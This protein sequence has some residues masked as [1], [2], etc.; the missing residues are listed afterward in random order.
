MDESRTTRRTFL[1]ASGGLL[2]LVG[3]GGALGDLR[4][5]PALRARTGETDVVLRLD[6]ADAPDEALAREAV[7]DH[8]KSHAETVQTEVRTALANESGVSVT[9]SFWLANALVA[10]VDTDRTRLDDLVALDGVERV[11]ATDALSAPARGSGEDSTVA[12][13]GP[14]PQADI[15]EEQDVSWVLDLL[16]VPEV[17]DRYGTRGEG[18]RVAILDTGVDTSHPDIE[19]DGWAEF[20][21]QG[22]RV[23]SDP[24]EVDQGVGHG[25]WTSTLATGGDES[26]M[27]IGVA[28]DAEL[29]VAGF[30]T[31][32]NF[33]AV[34]A[35]LEW[36]VEN[37]AEVASMSFTM[38]TRWLDVI[39][40][41]ENAVAAGTVP[42]TAIEW[43][44]PFLFN[45]TTPEMLVT[46]PITRDLVPRQGANGGRIRWERALR[47]F[48]VPADWPAD[49]FVP[50]VS[51]PGEEV[52]SG[53]SGPQFP[54]Q[55]WTPNGQGASA[56]PPFAAGIVALLQ[57]ATDGGLSAAK[58]RETFRKTAFQPE[59]ADEA[60]PNT[61][62]GYGIPDAARAM[63]RHA[64]DDQTVSGVVRDDEG[65]PVAGATVRAASGA[66]TSTDE[67]GSYTLS[68]PDGEETL[69]AR[70]VGYEDVEATVPGDESTAD[71][72]FESRITPAIERVEREPTQL[73]QGETL[74]LAFD[75]AHAD[76]ARVT[77]ESSGR[78]VDP[79]DFTVSINGRPVAIRQ[80]TGFESR[81]STLQIELTAHEDARGVAEFGV[82]VANLGGE[83]P[84]TTSLGL[85]PIHIHEQPLTVEGEEDIQRALDAATPDTRVELA[86]SE[87]TVDVGAIEPTVD[88]SLREYPPAAPVLERARDDQAALVVDKPLTLTAVDG[89]DPTVVVDDVGSGERTVAL[90]IGA[91]YV[92]VSDI[93]VDAGGA[94][95]GV[96]VLNGTGVTVEN[97]T[98]TNADY[99][100]LGELTLSLLAR[101]NDVTAADTGVRLSWIAWNAMVTDN[102]LRDADVGVELDSGFLITE[103][104]L[105]ENR[106]ESVGTEVETTGEGELSYDRTEAQSDDEQAGDGQTPADDP[107]PAERTVEPGTASPTA[108]PASTGTDTESGTGA[109]TTGEDGPGFG[110]GSAL[111]S[112][113]GLAYLLRRRLGDDEES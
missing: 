100:L 63:A 95:A 73:T 3:T 86:G 66:E 113:G 11:H 74:T 54:D 77:L 42:V 20:D 50:D 23:D 22:Q 104:Q 19:L 47:G 49:S 24:N 25:T 36:A 41:I 87:Y 102:D 28:P 96:S 12:A 61:R 67:D 55:N 27:A 89:A 83:E 59:D 98:V 79:D 58:L 6:T 9:G 30:G 29:Y 48:D 37:D 5:D 18:A 71:I 2:G 65:T 4:V 32:Y 56:T 35:G 93:T 68:V 21:P 110:V 62:L 16:N 40:P 15:F 97:V 72:A 84:A 80:E 44:V 39:E 46:A 64:G 1:S 109:T 94:S 75:V 88:D 69:T 53:V 60:V 57:S 52:P 45:A 34:M 92:T 8:L 13:T 10:T 91:S 17:W 101:S 78:R 85:D 70:A 82:G 26:G 111:T 33:P 31:E 38:E 112:L 7:R 76:G 103:T 51:V 108:T 81:P 107:T 106:F 105:A 43:P 99:G 14:S 90:R